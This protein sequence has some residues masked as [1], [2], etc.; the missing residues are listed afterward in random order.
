MYD[1]CNAMNPTSTLKEVSSMQFIN[2]YL[3]IKFHQM[4]I[5]NN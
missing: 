1:I 2:M 4:M 5:N 3:F